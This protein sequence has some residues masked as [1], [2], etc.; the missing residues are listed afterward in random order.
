VIFCARD[1]KRNLKGRPV[2][3][4]AAKISM[5]ELNE[6][7][8]SELNS[9]EKK[10]AK[11]ISKKKKADKKKALSLIEAKAREMGF[12]LSELT[13]NTRAPR[14]T[15][16]VRKPGVARFANPEDATQTWTGKGRRP[17]WVISWVE[18]GK[19]LDD[20]AI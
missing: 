5:A 7:S 16:K 15:A 19:N 10:I 17:A 9:L 14:G 4:N 12:S 18:A 20:L 1:E 11:A 2:L 3:A 6:L 8:L 13:G